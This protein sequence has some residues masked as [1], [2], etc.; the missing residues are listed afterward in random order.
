M[1]IETVGKAW[2]ACRLLFVWCFTLY[3]LGVP[4]VYVYAYVFPLL[5]VGRFAGRQRL[6]ARGITVR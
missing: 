4:N 2:A 5:I 6:L 3:G 1:D